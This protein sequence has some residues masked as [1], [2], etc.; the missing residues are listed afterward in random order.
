MDDLLKDG[1]FKFIARFPAAGGEK[2]PTLA[3]GTPR[4]SWGDAYDD[5][6]AFAEKV[7]SERGEDALST[8]DYRMVATCDDAEELISQFAEE[9]SYD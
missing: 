7:L 5:L 9:T 3:V 2:Y 4:S 6:C 1:P 8:C